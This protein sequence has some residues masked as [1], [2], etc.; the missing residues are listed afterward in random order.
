MKKKNSLKSA[1]KRDENCQVVR[2][3]K[4]VFVIN[5]RKPRFK[6]VQG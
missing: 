1:K 3:G 2:R 5:K 6:A 4:R